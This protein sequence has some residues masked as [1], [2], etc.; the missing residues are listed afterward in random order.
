MDRTYVLEWFQ[1]IK[2][3]KD[4]GFRADDISE[5]NSLIAEL[6][7]NVLDYLHEDNGLQVQGYLKSLIIDIFDG[8]IILKKSGFGMNRITGVLEEMKSAYPVILSE[9][10]YDDNDD[11]EDED[12]EYDEVD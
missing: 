6:L 8:V 9:D 1:G 4:E 2:K 7:Q 10:D 12:D 3:L 11:D 5:I